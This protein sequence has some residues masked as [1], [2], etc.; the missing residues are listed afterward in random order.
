MPITSENMAAYRELQGGLSARIIAGTFA[1]LT[2]GETA[3]IAALV[4]DMPARKFNP[5]AALLVP[6][7]SAAASMPGVDLRDAKYGPTSL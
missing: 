5:L 2:E 3:A 4:A 1:G 7:T 6:Y